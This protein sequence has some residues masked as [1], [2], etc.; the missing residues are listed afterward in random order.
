MQANSQHQNY[1][2]FIWPFEFETCGKEGQKLQKIEYILKEENI[3]GIKSIFMIFEM[4][5][6]GKL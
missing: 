2:N 4:F 3:C 5:S 6:F 1:S